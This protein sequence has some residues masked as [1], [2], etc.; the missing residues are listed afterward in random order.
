VARPLRS[1]NLNL[2]LNLARRPHPARSATRATRIGDTYPF[3][4]ACS[5]LNH[6]GIPGVN[7]ETYRGANSNVTAFV[8]AVA[9]ADHHCPPYPKPCTGHKFALLCPWDAPCYIRGKQAFLLVPL[10]YCLFT[11]ELQ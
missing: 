8:D 2:N 9:A 11:P 7:D 1:Q 3:E 4:T 5:P 6:S 10:Q